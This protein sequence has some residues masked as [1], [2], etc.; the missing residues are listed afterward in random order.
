MLV[1][2]AMI[3]ALQSMIE[4]IASDNGLTANP[5]SESDAL[6]LKDFKVSP[7]LDS[8]L[9]MSKGGVK[10]LVSSSE[11]LEIGRN[12]LRSSLVMRVVSVLQGRV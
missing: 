11:S 3:A 12:R 2:G 1:L 7:R 10:S 8:S 9:L 5:L 6:D 4:G